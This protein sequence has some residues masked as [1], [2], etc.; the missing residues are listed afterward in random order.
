MNNQGTWV[1]IETHFNQLDPSGLQLLTKAKSISSE[2]VSAILLETTSQSFEEQLGKYGAD[3]VI[4]VKNDQ[5]NN[6]SDTVASDVLVQLV[7]KYH[8]N[9]FLFGATIEGRSIAPRV[10]GA[11]ETGLT[12]DC[13]DFRVEDNLL[14]AVKPSYGDNI[15]CEIICPDARPQMATVR[16]NTF[17]ADD[18]HPANAEIIIESIN[19]GTDPLIQVNDETAL[20][21]DETNIA[22][23]SRIIALGRGAANE[24]A[25]DLA[26]QIAVKI[27]AVIAVSRPLTDLDGFSHEQQI[28]QSGST[29]A[30]DLLINVGISGAVQYSVGIKNAKTVISVN[31]DAK[32]PIFESSDYKYVGDSNSFLEGFLSKLS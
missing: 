29:V 11:L 16:P 15:M 31:K 27:G 13:L 1:F 24:K 8:P 6:A 10:Q 26:K 21:A 28:G 7:Q 5:L 30:P 20:V 9:I 18:S 32:A 22:S 4:V 2:P 19:V 23:A 17:T 3:Q 25:V 14:I 12:A